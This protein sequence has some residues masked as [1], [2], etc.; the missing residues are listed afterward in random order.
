MKSNAA[1]SSGGEVVAHVRRQPNMLPSPTALLR[2]CVER[3]KM[4][5]VDVEP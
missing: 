1:L 2:K 5:E 3:E 4:N